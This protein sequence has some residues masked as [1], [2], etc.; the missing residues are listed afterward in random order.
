MNS[1]LETIISRVKFSGISEST[2]REYSSA[3]TRMGDQNW[4][5][6]AEEHNL[7]KRSAS[8]LRAAWR[9]SI[10][11]RIL[12]A[13]ETVENVGAEES[14]K[15]KDTASNLSL[16]LALDFELPAYKA[17]PDTQRPGHKSKRKSLKGLPDDWRDIMLEFA[18]EKDRLPLLVMTLTGCRP[19]EL[20]KGVE[21]IKSG[22]LIAFIVQGAKVK[23]NAGQKIRAIAIDPKSV[24]S[25]NEK[26]IDNLLSSKNVIRIDDDQSFQ[27][28]I[29]RISTKLGFKNVS[30]YTLRH[31]LAAD[32]K[33][34]KNT[35]T[36]IALLLG[37]QSEGTQR[38]YGNHKQGNKGGR[39]IEVHAHAAIPPRPQEKPS[40]DQMQGS[41]SESASSSAM[42]STL[43]PTTVMPDL[44]SS[45]SQ[46]ISKLAGHEL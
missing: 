29:Y 15:A 30:C 18:K 38:F 39:V 22:H 21:V 34:N 37:H 5:E 12:W 6:Y 44:K 31:Q 17:P 43:T 9:W 45:R 14:Q 19:A 23:E 10:A 33:S 26:L 11:E 7:S 35:R 36:E 46:K 2:K 3:C 40:F 32:L 27:K 1:V 20:K 25:R 28:R 16:Q 41:F 24:L 4:R 8:I 13:S 42:Q